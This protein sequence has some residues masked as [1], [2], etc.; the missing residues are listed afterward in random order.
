MPD[1]EKLYE[2]IIKDEIKELKEMITNLRAEVRGEV[3]KQIGAMRN[4]I[5]AGFGVLGTGMGAIYTY[6][7]LIEQRLHDHELLFGHVGIERLLIQI[8][9]D[10]HV[11]Q[12]AVTTLC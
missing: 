11:V 8:Q 9:Q 6:V 2:H 3:D 5:M 7:L 10:I 1:N 4:M 12:C